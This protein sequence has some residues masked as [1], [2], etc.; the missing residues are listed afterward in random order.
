MNL[1]PLDELLQD[2]CPTLMVPRYADLPAMTEAGHRY[3]MAA[4]GLYIEVLRPW[5]HL[6]ML[7]SG[8]NGFSFPYGAIEPVFNLRFTGE[9]LRA[10]LT[11]FMHE[12][13]QAAPKESAGWLM[14]NPK[15]G[16]LSFHRPE[17]LSQGNAHVHYLRPEVREDS[18]PVVDCHSHGHIPAFFSGED[19]QDDLADD[20][21]ISFVIG[22]L[23]SDTPTVAMRLVGLGGINFDLTLWLEQL[24]PNTSGGFSYSDC[25]AQY[26]GIESDHADQQQPHH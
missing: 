16:Q 6:R 22:S 9:A 1:H 4:D 19:D 7:I 3:L 12:A 25:I 26:N 10:S 14:F 11:R 8:N 17:L 24:I 20:L 5:L 15:S 23:G 2:R 18:Q 13:E 21:K